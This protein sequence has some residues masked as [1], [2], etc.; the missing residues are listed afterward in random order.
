[1]RR[2]I[3]AMLT[4]AVLLGLAIAVP[5]TAAA[6]TVTAQACAKELGLQVPSS[7]DAKAKT[8]VILVHGLWGNGNS[9]KS[10]D[11]SL[12]SLPIATYRF[13]YQSVNDHWVTEG[14]TAQRLAKTIV[15][16]SKLYDGKKVI[17]VVHSMGGLLTR[18]ALDWAAYGTFAKKAVG[19]I[20]TIGTPHKGANI[21]DASYIA[22]TSLCNAAFFWWGEDAQ[23]NCN[24][25]EEGKA[26]SAM[27]P[28][29]PELAALPHIP[30]GITV[31]AIA[32][33]V[34]A[35]PVCTPWSCALVDSNSDLVVPV[36]S[37]TDEYTST[38]VGD[39]KKVYACTGLNWFESMSQ[40]WCSHS[41]L[42]KAPEVQADVRASIQAYL[43]SLKPQKLPLPPHT[44]YD[45]FTRF[46]LPF[47]STWDTS[48]SEPNAVLNVADRSICSADNASCPHI[49]FI[50]LTSSYG[51][52]TYGNDPVGMVARESCTTAGQ[53]LGSVG[54]GQSVT[55]GGVAARYY[56]EIK[57][58][59]GEGY[60]QA[61]WYVPSK[62]LLVTSPSAD[63]GPSFD[64]DGLRAVLDNIEW[65]S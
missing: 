65:I 55:V 10:M 20:V 63:V 22:N 37:A 29:S 48:M 60:A 47:L 32:G 15:C 4:L 40:A 56:P 18:A 38:G 2:I 8:P 9:L 27:R 16:Y 59:N 54:P 5:A 3:T 14:D 39:G 7:Q 17:I 26:V 52:Q 34:K 1:M 51:K 11:E 36:S 23:Q 28:G 58:A 21:S 24:T 41:N 30:S 49:Y 6:S 61:I 19:H 31:R 12:V 45:F 50:D 46:K 25:V 42:T 44:M 64:Y 57:C 43:A 33:D 53:G 62:Q 35:P 13:N